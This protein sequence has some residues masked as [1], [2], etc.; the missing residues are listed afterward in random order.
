MLFPLSLRG[1]GRNYRSGRRPKPVARRRTAVP[2][3]EPLEVRNVLSTLTLTP[4]VRVSDTTTPFTDMSDLAGQRGHV[5]LNSA[6]EPNLAVDPVDSQ[7][8][9]AAWQQDRWSNGG[10]RGI[11]SAWSTTGG[12]SWTRVVVPGLT[13]ASGGQ[14]QRASDPWVTIAANGTVYVASLEVTLAPQGFPLKSA[15]LVNRSTD[16]GKSWGN[17]TTLVVNT[18]PFPNNLFNDKPSVT[19]DPTKPGRVFVVWDRGVFP[20]DNAAFD[21]V[22]AGVAIRQDIL[23]ATTT[24]SGQTWTTSTIRSPRADDGE[25]GNQIVVEPD[26]NGTLVDVF[27]LTRGSGKQPAQAVQQFQ[28]VI[29]STDHGA[30]WSDPVI[31]S[32]VEGVAVTDPDTG[33][34]VRSGDDSHLPEIAVDR[35]N[36]NLYAVWADGRFSDLSH[37]DI[38]LSMSTDG[39]LHWS[40]PVKVNQTPSNIPVGDQQAFTANVAVADNHTVAV[41]Y[42][43]FRNN[44][45]APGLLTDYWLVHAD[46]SSN[47]TDPASWSQ[48]NRLT[49]TSFDLELAARTSRGYFL[50]DYMSLQAAGDSFDALFAQTASSANP[51]NIWFRDPPPAVAP[52]SGPSASGELTPQ[53]PPALGIDVMAGIGAGPG[54]SGLTVVDQ[55]SSQVEQLPALVGYV[56]PGKV[57]A[58]P[59]ADFLRPNGRGMKSATDDEATLDAIFSGAWDNPLL[60]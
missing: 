33:A 25:T 43:D 35:G 1:R 19:A 45:S 8:L 53:T 17:P 10:A 36:G 13:L 50:G 32:G 41:S 14:Y 47:F 58:G 31:I 15:I 20:G 34:P 39:G 4:P 56:E 24:D 60:G 40:A 49:D 5:A 16:G 59:S 21:A 3:L 51:S 7:H 30:T 44:T 38:A 11:V 26:G 42:Y 54:R 28:A 6:G 18:S 23:L 9:V 52:A 57:L 22:H 46:A 2:L 48:E 27:A 12:A 29:R 37:D 55:R